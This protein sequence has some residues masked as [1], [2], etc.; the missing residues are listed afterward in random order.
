MCKAVE[1]YGMKQ[2]NEGIKEGI[3]EGIREG[4]REGIIKSIMKMI[5]QGN[6]KQTKYSQKITVSA[7]AFFLC[8]AIS[9]KAC[10][11]EQRKENG[12]R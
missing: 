12:W 5:K 4:I 3:K 8:K 10:H 1:E 6:G 2:R 7:D 9:C 11:D